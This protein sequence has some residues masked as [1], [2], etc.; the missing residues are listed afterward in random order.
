MKGRTTQGLPAGEMLMPSS[1]STWGCSK[2][3]MMTPSRRNFSMCAI[4]LALSPLRVL[5]ATGTSRPPGSR[6]RPRRFYEEHRK[7]AKHAP[8]RTHKLAKI[9]EGGRR[10]GKKRRRNHKESIHKRQI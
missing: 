6:I 5:T 2:C 10:K 4:S 8:V 7:Q 9:E 3:F 1:E